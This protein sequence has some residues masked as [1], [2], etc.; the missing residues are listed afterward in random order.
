MRTAVLAL[1]F[2]ALAGCA[3]ADQPA[4]G[5][6]YVAMGSSFAA[7]PGIPSYYED[8]PQPCARSTGNYAHQIAARRGLTLIDVSCSGAVTAHL[9]G[10]RNDIPPQLD[11]L[12]SDTR[13]VTITIG[14][15]DLSY[16]ARLTTASCAGLAAAQPTT[17]TP[18]QPTTQ[19]TTQPCNPIPAQ[20]TEPTFR[21]LAARM[22]HIAKE[23]RRRSPHAQLVF[24]DYL[25]VLPQSGTCPAT[26]LS[27]AEADADREIARRLAEITRM[28]AG[29]NKASVITASEFSKGHDA[30]SADPWM[31]GFSRPGAPVAGTQYH[32]NAKGMT[33]VAD[34]LEKLLWP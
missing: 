17:Q 2:V 28:T 24:V 13:L 7:G 4:P 8:P 26:P 23:V 30:C 21:D 20:P 19:A 33:A 15:N 18:A 6:T 27:P 9:T 22:D 3:T 11:A 1:S 10:P 16:I 5:A 12:T 29:A 25:A 32:P 31:N 14:G 34:A